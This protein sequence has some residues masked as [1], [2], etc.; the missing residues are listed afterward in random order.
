MA[1]VGIGLSLILLA[2]YA[3][4]LVVI[5]RAP[6]RALAVLVAGMA[7]HNIVLMFLIDLGT[8]ALLLR[9]VQFWKEGVLLLLAFMAGRLAVQAWRAGKGPR[10]SWLDWTMLAFAVLSFVYLVIPDWAF[11][12]ES[13]L[14]QR[15][16]SFRVML[17]LP[18]LYAFG[19]VFWRYTRPDLVWTGRVLLGSILVVAVFG[20]WELWFVPTPDWLDWG[21]NGFTSW[22][23]YG[24]GGPKGLPENFFQGTDAG[25]LLRRMVSTYI[26][27]LGLAYTGLLLVPIGTVLVTSR[28]V[29]R[30][31]PAWF[32][33]AAFVALLATILFSITRGALIMLVLEFG[34][35]ILL[36]RRRRTLV[37]GGIVA[38]TVVF[39]LIEYVNFGP[40]VTF[41]L[42]EVRPPLGLAAVRQARTMAPG[43]SGSPIATAVA[44]PTQKAGQSNNAGEQDTK[45]GELVERMLTR[46]D[47]ST[48]GHIEALRVGA[49][50]VAKYPLGTGLGSSV[51][52]FGSAEGPAESALLAV[53]GEIGLLGGLI[54]TL[55]Y[56]ASIVYSFLAYRRVRGDPLSEGLA[57]VPMVGGLALVPIMITSAIWGNFS[58]TFLFWWTSGLC[59]SLIREQ[60]ESPTPV[61]N[62]ERQEDTPKEP[63]RDERTLAL[64]H[65]V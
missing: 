30:E 38:A 22:L 43:Q 63:E 28:N 4:L 37:T 6:F 54:Y 12:I 32:R 21:V 14:N 11:P 45:G 62:Q 10:L 27:P 41:S 55:M 56:G 17:L 31:L 3:W 29:A 52:R 53:F 25:Y 23:G 64:P 15:L 35:L 7:F 20:L 8:P 60:Q 57:L 46:E 2:L 48:R 5:Y 61:A 39:I 58:V 36:I 16:V 59:L 40:L 51:P 34:L 19:R 13:S 65:T 47:P 50:H 33:T 9:M 24:Y 18:L 44:S 1:I 49:I 26:S 42:E